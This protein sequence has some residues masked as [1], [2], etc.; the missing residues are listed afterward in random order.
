MR[1]SVLDRDADSIRRRRRGSGRETCGLAAFCALW[2]VSAVAQEKS[3]PAPEPRSTGLPTASGLDWTFH[4]DASWGT[5]GF[6]NSL[7]TDPKPEQPSGNL[8]DNWF[9]G[10]VKPALTATYTSSK[11]WQLYGTVSVVG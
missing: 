4:L 3:P 1:C 6:M 5:F 9:E 2:A 10:A 8:G 7:Y 11:S